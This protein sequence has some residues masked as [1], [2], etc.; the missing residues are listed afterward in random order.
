M[1][2]QSHPANDNGQTLS[3]HCSKRFCLV[4]RWGL[5]ASVLLLPFLRPAPAAANGPFTAADF[6][7]VTTHP[8]APLQPTVQGQNLWTLYPFEGYLYAGYGDWNANTGPIWIS[9]F[10]LASETWQPGLNYQTESIELFREI[11]TKLYAPGIDPISST[12]GG[13]AIG[14]RFGDIVFWGPYDTAQA[15]HVF[16]VATLDGTD[17]WMTGS[18]DL[19]GMVWRSADGGVTWQISRD[20]PPATGSFSRYYG[21]AVL[22]GKLYVQRRDSGGFDVTESLVFDGSQWSAGPDML[23][24]GG[25]YVWKPSVFHDELVYLSQSNNTGGGGY[26][27]QFDGVQATPAYSAFSVETP[28]APPLDFFLADDSLYLLT[29]FR[30][31]VVTKDLEHW[32]LLGNAPQDSKSLAVVGNFLYVGTAGSEIHRL[33]LVPEPASA[34]LVISAAV[35]MMCCRAGRKGFLSP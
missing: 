31:I 26:L 6:E 22:D 3:T 15:T 32:Q 28:Y 29:V 2:Y 35:A 19:N 9:G 16:D 11:G 13:V 20:D 21:A 34:L 12:F 27:F 10:D 24:L 4:A 33:R 23:P 7:F 30:E 14:E 1:P 8:Q 18:R 5:I 25:A 17:L